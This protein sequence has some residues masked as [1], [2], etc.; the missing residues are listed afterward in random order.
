MAIFVVDEER[1][2]LV[3]ALAA[4]RHSRPLG[5]HAMAIG[6]R[7]S[8]WVAATGQPMIDADAALDLFDIP[9][10]SLR[11]ALAVPCSGPGSVQAVLTLYSAS[12]DAFSSLHQRLLAAAAA[13]VQA[14]GTGPRAREGRPHSLRTAAL[15][16]HQV[17]LRSRSQYRWSGLHPLVCCQPAPGGRCAAIELRTS[18]DHGFGAAV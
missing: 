2:R 16:R 8:G 1:H 12:P 9:G 10:C 6:E 4:G 11:T 15:P 17:A 18:F 5:Q 7:L 14:S 3:A 13:Y